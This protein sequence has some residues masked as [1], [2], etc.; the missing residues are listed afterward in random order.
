MWVKMLYL[1]VKTIM[2]F[3]TIMIWWKEVTQ[4][5]RV[6]PVPA[7]WASNWKMKDDQPTTRH[8]KIDTVLGYNGANKTTW[9]NGSCLQLCN[10]LKASWSPGSHMLIWP[11]MQ[12]NTR[13]LTKEI[14]IWSCPSCLISKIFLT[15]WAGRG[16][17]LL[18]PH[19][20]FSMRYPL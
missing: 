9:K 10:S 4:M 15:F 12:I 7:W 6:D 3:I 5:S 16:Q 11:G 17:C 14:R 20:C 2:M 8:L 13:I 1:W 19:N 18:W